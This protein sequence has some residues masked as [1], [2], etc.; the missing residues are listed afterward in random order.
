MERLTMIDEAVRAQ[1]IDLDVEALRARFNTAAMGSLR[2]RL[3]GDLSTA[4]KLQR[5]AMLTKR[6]HDSV[7]A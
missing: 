2:A 7:D 3:R 1:G 6:M 4:A 5:E